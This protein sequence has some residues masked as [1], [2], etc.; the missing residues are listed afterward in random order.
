M[1]ARDGQIL[2]FCTVYYIKNLP[3]VHTHFFPNKIGFTYIRREMKILNYFSLGFLFYTYVRIKNGNYVFLMTVRVFFQFD[4]LLINGTFTY[5]WS[6]F[7][8]HTKIKSKA[9]KNNGIQQ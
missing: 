5:R 8:K 6:G 2:V 1:R 4:Y 7:R 9:K 3:Y